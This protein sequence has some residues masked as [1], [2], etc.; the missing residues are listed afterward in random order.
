MGLLFLYCLINIWSLVYIVFDF[1]CNNRLP[2]DWDYLEKYNI[3]G[4][5]LF[6]IPFWLSIVIFYELVI[7]MVLM[8]ELYEFVFIKK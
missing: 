5:I 1:A 7:V 8:I 4:K 3:F 6:T 2:S